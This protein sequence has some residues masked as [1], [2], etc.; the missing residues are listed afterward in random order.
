MCVRVMK[1]CTGHTVHRQNIYIQPVRIFSMLQF[2]WAKLRLW[3][4]NNVTCVER[5]SLCI[6]R[7]GFWIRFN[8]VHSVRSSSDD[9]NGDNN[10]SDNGIRDGDDND[11]NTLEWI[12]FC[13]VAKHYLC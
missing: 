10:D 8:A 13:V 5:V 3:Q 11:Y 9:D 2:R 1:A 6:S 12:Q 7:Y 4:N